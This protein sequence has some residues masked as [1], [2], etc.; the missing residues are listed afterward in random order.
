MLIPLIAL[1]ILM[2]TQ[3]IR[4]QKS[5]SVKN[6]LK[7]YDIEEEEQAKVQKVYKNQLIILIILI[8][9][10]IGLGIVLTVISA[11]IN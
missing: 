9:I 2:A 4:L 11:S 10:T 1:C 6:Q 7:L 3:I 5:R 8:A